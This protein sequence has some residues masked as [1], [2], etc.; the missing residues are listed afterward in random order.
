MISKLEKKL[1]NEW[2]KAKDR[3]LGTNRG[4]GIFLS[5]IS[6]FSCEKEKKIIKRHHNLST[7]K[8]KEFHDLL[9]PL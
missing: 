9:E 1:E 5:L 7:K 4:K 6:R 3:C 2:G 8:A